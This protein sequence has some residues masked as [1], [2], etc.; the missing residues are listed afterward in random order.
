M[1]RCRK[2]F[3]N[4]G[5]GC[6]YRVAYDA[7]PENLKMLAP[8]GP[9][10]NIRIPSLHLG[11]LL[12]QGNPGLGRVSIIAPFIL[13]DLRKNRRGL[14]CEAQE[15]EGRD[16]PGQAEST[17]ARLV[18]RHLRQSQNR[19]PR[20]LGYVCPGEQQRQHSQKRQ[21]SQSGYCRCFGTEYRFGD[22]NLAL[23][24]LWSTTAPPPL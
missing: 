2:A 4:Y 17:L 21:Q 5:R 3:T 23:P 10:R 8:Q 15:Y 22:L 6:K 7:Q 16:A 19:R 14:A 1:V 20:N 24:F 13:T 12:N 9:A 11:H 18:V